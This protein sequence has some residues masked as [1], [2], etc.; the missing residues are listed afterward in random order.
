MEGLITSEAPFK[1]RILV[2]DDDPTALRLLTYNLLKW[3]FDVVT[4]TDGEEAW[5]IIQSGGVD[6]ALLDWTMPKMEG[7]DV[8]RNA[9]RMPARRGYLYIILLTAKGSVEEVVEGLNAGADDYLRKPYDED[10]LRSRIAVGERII[11]LERRLAANIAALKEALETNKV[12]NGLLPICMYC[13]KIR[14]DKD[15]WHQI[16]SFIHEHTDADFTHSVCP[17]CR[18]QVVKPMLEALR[19]DKEIR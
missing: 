15:Y 16:E 19:K 7:V 17:D 9:R 4:A 14:D 13:K 10:E 1:L 8:C 3:N 5:E 12:L 11:A 18:D 6:I 2:A